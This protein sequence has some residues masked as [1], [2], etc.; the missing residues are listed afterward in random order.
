MS[1]AGELKQ[2]FSK[3]THRPVVRMY[4]DTEIVSKFHGNGKKTEITPECKT[5][6]TPTN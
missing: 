5:L 4:T 1:K 3:T 6:S 2:L